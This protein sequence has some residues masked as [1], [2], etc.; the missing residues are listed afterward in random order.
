MRAAAGLPPCCEISSYGPGWRRARPPGDA[1]VPAI[2]G[3]TSRRLRSRISPSLWL[4]DE[5]VV[6]GYEMLEVGSVFRTP[7]H[8]RQLP[9][10]RRRDHWRLHLGSQWT[11]RPARTARSR[12]PAIPLFT[13]DSHA[14]D[15][16]QSIAQPMPADDRRV[17]AR[18]GTAHDIG[19]DHESGL[20]GLGGSG[21]TTRHEPQCPARGHPQASCLTTCVHRSHDISQLH[22]RCAWCENDPGRPRPA[23]RCLQ[24]S[25]AVSNRRRLQSRGFLDNCRRQDARSR[26]VFTRKRDREPLM[27]PTLSTARLAV[28]T[29]CWIE[30]KGAVSTQ[31]RGTAGTSANCSA[32]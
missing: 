16:I 9:A 28:T 30:R 29:S 32:A 13:I 7:G 18:L 2:G 23:P 1:E 4:R 3:T 20:G 15:S 24:A 10:I 27:S 5:Q 12:V 17:P 26:G 19:I 21:R 8:A 14:R 11:I 6:D 25:P 22:V 31:G